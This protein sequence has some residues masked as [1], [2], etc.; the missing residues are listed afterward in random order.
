MAFLLVSF[1][2]LMAAF[3][4]QKLK[5]DQ[6]FASAW[7]VDLR[8]AETTYMPPN[9]AVRFLALG[10]EAF[11]A[12]LVFMSAHSYFATHLS[13]DRKYT[14]LD[15]YV[16]AVTGYCRDRFGRKRMLP[17]EECEP[18]C[19]SDGDCA[20]EGARCELPCSGCEGVC[21][22]ELETHWVEG[23]FPFN[24]RVFLWASQVVK[25]APLLTNEIIDRS[26]YYGKTGIHYCPDNWELYFD[27]GFNLYF[28]YKDLSQEERQRRKLVGLDYFSVA[29][30]LPGSSVD[31][32]FVAGNLWDKTESERAIEQIYLTYYHA[33]GQQ[34]QEIRSR[35]RAYGERELADRLEEEEN[36][37]EEQFHYLPQ[38][39]FHLLGSLQTPASRAA[40]MP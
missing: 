18:S 12:D 38:S 27:V 28:E 14:W 9:E 29:S 30:V 39:L 7:E 17:P 5:L 31:P 35:A 6:K 32:N 13:F 16:D 23:I 15:T 20:E 8:K 33:S 11:I 10:Y 37:W 19:A 4:T 1:L 36:R 40:E 24:P 22:G 3:G 26:V 2:F 25:F 34:R 21:V